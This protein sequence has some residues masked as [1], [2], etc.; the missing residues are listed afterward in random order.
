[1]SKSGNK[2]NDLFELSKKLTHIKWKYDKSHEDL[3][4]ERNKQE[5]TF[6]P[7]SYRYN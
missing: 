3:D 1:M 5:C 2:H 6:K 7:N 4:Y